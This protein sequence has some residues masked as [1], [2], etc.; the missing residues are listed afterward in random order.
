MEKIRVQDFIEEYSQLNSDKFKENYIKKNLNLRYVPYEDKVAQAVNCLK[1]N[2]RDKEFIEVN[3]PIVY[4]N[5]V[6]SVLDLYTNLELDPQKPLLTYNKLQEY[7][8]VDAIMG[9]LENEPD[10]I[11][12]NTIYNMCQSDFA[13]NYLSPRGFI[14]KQVQKLGVACNAGLHALGDAIR[15][16]DKESLKEIAETL[17]QIRK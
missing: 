4:L 17:K 9:L 15:S 16:M 2:I 3:T 5:Y 12:Y 6:M 13:Q 8:I 14:Q 7:R 1:G 11:E 10:V